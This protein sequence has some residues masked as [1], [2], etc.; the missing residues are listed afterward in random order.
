[1]Y[2]LA[3]AVYGLYILYQKIKARNAKVRSY[4]MTKTFYRALYDINQI[5]NCAWS[6]PQ[7]ETRYMKGLLHH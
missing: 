1:M 5:W 6:N 4:T 2:S 3:I 7:Y